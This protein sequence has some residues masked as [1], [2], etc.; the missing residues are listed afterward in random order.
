MD[1]KNVFEIDKPDWHVY[2][3]VDHLTLAPHNVI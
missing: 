3:I 1:S 2:T